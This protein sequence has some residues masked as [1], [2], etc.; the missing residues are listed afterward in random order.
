MSTE[1]EAFPI[2]QKEEGTQ[3]HYDFADVMRVLEKSYLNVMRID[4][5]E[6]IYFGGCAGYGLYGQAFFQWG[7]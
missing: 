2:E 1:R 7:S 6:D 3:A 4:L 5:T